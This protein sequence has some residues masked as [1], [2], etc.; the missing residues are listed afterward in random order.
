MLTDAIISILYRSSSTVAMILWLALS[1]C[2]FGGWG[3]FALPVILVPLGISVYEAA[4]LRSNRDL[5]GR[6]LRAERACNGL[7]LAVCVSLAL[8][9]ALGGVAALFYTQ[10][11][12]RN[13][14]TSSTSESGDRRNN[15][16]SC[17]ERQIVATI[18]WVATFLTLALAI[19]TLYLDPEHGMTA[20]ARRLQGGPDHTMSDE[21]ILQSWLDEQPP[22]GHQG[23]M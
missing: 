12:V 23:T 18:A 21:E 6:S 14:F 5:G 16:Y 3:L 1:L 4:F 19:V 11:H 10:E 20:T 15:H 22:K 2:A 8:I 7:L 13:E 9:C 17:K